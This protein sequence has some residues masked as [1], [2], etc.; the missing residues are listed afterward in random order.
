MK[1][2][3]GN[4]QW[5]WCQVRSNMNENMPMQGFEV[6]KDGRVGC[7]LDWGDASGLVVHGGHLGL[8]LDPVHVHDSLGKYFW[9]PRKMPWQTMKLEI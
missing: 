7:K 8:G 5:D 4:V 3:G 9:N 1:Q 2:W 6:M